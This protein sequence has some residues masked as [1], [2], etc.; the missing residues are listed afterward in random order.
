MNGGTLSDVTHPE[1]YPGGIHLSHTRRYTRWYT[2]VT[3]PE[4]HPGGYNTLLHTLRYTL[5]GDT[6]VPHPEVH[7]GGYMPP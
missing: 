3:H 7:P 4:V 2:P 5:V 6:A 1:V